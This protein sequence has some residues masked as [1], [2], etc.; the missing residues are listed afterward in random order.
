MAEVQLGRVDATITDVLNFLQKDLDTLAGVES[1]HLAF[2][3]KL[4]LLT[5]KG[6]A[7]P[8]GVKVQRSDIA[9]GRSYSFETSHHAHTPDQIGPYVTSVP[10]ETSVAFAFH[11]AIDTVKSYVDQAIRNKHAFDAAWLIPNPHY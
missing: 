11:R 7:Y 6:D 2:E 8:L 10:Y 4:T 1:A 5:E 9:E 3:V